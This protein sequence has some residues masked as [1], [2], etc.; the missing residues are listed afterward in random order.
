MA[1][2][3]EPVDV[4]AD[5]TVQG[6]V[7]VIALGAFV[8]HAPIVIPVLA[9]ALG[10]GAALGPSGNVLH[11]IFGALVAPR[12]SPPPA[13]VPAA[14]VQAQDLLGAALLGLATLGILI[15]LDPITT[16]ATL[17]PRRD[18]PRPAPP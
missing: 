18:R 14:T 5:R 8:F 12:L 3:S 2:G 10:A 9:A 15:R 16:L 7:T 11:R 1:A 13:V 6:A 17:A 4:R